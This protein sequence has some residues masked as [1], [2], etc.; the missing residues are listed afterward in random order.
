M[1]PPDGFGAA[2]GPLESRGQHEVGSGYVSDPQ[3][4]GVKGDVGSSAHTVA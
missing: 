1:A 3:G 4:H 2:Q